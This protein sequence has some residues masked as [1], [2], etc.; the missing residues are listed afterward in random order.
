MVMRC[1]QS[2][3]NG[4]VIMLTNKFRSSMQLQI[5]C[6]FLT[7]ALCGT[8][9]S[10]LAAGYP[11]RPVRV[12]VPSQAGGGS[13]TTMRLVATKLG[14]HLGQQIV[15]DN[16][17]GAS[18]NLGAEVVARA[19]PDGYTLVS[20]FASHTSNVAVMKKVPFDL[21][22]DFAPISLM[23][24]LPNVIVSHPSLPAK[25]VKDLVALGKARPG[26]LQYA[27]AGVGSN[28]HL[29]MALFLNMTGLD[30]IH[31]PYKASPQGVIDVIAGHVPLMVANI[32]VALPHIK[33]GR[34]RVYGVTSAKRSSAAPEIPTIV[35]SGVPDY[36]AVQWY[37]L[38]APAATPR[39]I[40]S[41]LHA[42]VVLALQDPPTRKRFIDDGAEPAP[43]ASPEEFGTFVRSEVVKWG[44]VVK[45]AGIQ[46]E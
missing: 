31:V 17:A 36:E 29:T 13:D 5:T 28:A 12:I 38:F 18:G 10:P 11:E 1:T 2:L 43:S 32:L 4:E 14:D 3:K 39:E 34:M 21:V 19:A 40:I 8:A 24:T 15:V 6:L 33:T 46:P 9:P 42:G 7:A 26:Q 41:K 44:K 25:T 27:T 30:M 22:R 45:A 16:R 35:E 20:L 23:V 37:G